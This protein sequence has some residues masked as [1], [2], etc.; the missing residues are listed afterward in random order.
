MP[1]RVK[2]DAARL[3]N[4]GDRVQQILAEKGIRVSDSEIVVT[5]ATN[6]MPIVTAQV[7]VK[8]KVQARTI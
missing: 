2:V 3:A 6:G 4:A 5:Q 7:P 8:G 1:V